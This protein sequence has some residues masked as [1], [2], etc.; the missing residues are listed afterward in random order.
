MENGY[1][2]RA[3]FENLDVVLDFALFVVPSQDCP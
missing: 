2:T 3:A 1:F